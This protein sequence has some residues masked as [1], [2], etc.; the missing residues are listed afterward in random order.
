MCVFDQRD[1]VVDLDDVR[2][3]R[4]DVYSLA[5]GSWREI[6]ATILR[7]LCLISSSV[8]ITETVF[9]LATLT[10]ESDTDSEFV[11]SFHIGSESFTLLNGPPLP[12]SRANSY[13]NVLAVCH[14]KLA[15]FRHYIVGNFESCSFDLWVLEESGVDRESWLKMYSVGPFSTILYPLSIWRGEVVCRAEVNR[16]GNDDLR[17]METVVSLFNPLRNELK[18]LPAAHRDE[19]CYVPFTYAES[20]V[21]V[22]N[23]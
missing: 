2:V 6:D 15:M 10:S 17:R 4:A 22:S 16:D 23:I 12:A 11:V 5:T 13:S 3:D 18:N 19:F 20:L 1:Q 14:D 7:P 8:A 9:W 21:P